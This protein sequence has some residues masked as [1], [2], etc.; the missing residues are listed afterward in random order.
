TLFMKSPPFLRISL[1]SG[2]NGPS[3]EGFVK[4]PSVSAAVSYY[5]PFSF[6]PT[7]LSLKGEGEYLEFREPSNSYPSDDCM[8]LLALIMGSP[9]NSSIGAACDEDAGG[10]GDGDRSGSS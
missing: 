1:G 4:S 8:L 6:P 10:D 7:P 9:E 2:S 5:F 3:G